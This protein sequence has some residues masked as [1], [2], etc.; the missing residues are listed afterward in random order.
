MSMRNFEP[1]TYT[2]NPLA[3]YVVNDTTSILI[4][5]LS[6]YQYEIAFLNEQNYE[7][8]DNENFSVLKPNSS[9]P[10]AFRKFNN[11]DEV[12]PLLNLYIRY[13]EKSPKSNEGW[14]EIINKRYEEILLAMKP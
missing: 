12:I 14:W 9:S 4:K 10:K 7:K 1:K 11:F 3:K 5:H 6:L 2:T 8:F 13:L